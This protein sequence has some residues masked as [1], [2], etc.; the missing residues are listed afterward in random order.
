MSSLL[1]KTKGHF[2]KMGENKKMVLIKEVFFIH[3]SGHRKYKGGHYKQFF[4]INTIKFFKKAKDN[5]LS[6]F[7]KFRVVALKIYFSSPNFL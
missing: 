5:A 2:L 7:I 4:S 6:I 1:E 3:T